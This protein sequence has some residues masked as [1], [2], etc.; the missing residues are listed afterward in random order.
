MIESEIVFAFVTKSGR[1]TCVNR[2]LKTSWR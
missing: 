2:V 1:G